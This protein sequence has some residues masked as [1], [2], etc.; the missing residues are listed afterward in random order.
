MNKKKLVFKQFSID[1]K[2]FYNRFLKYIVFISYCIYF[3]YSLFYNDSTTL[4]KANHKYEYYSRDTGLKMTLNAKFPKYLLHIH[5][6]ASFVLVMGA[7]FLKFSTLQLAKASN[8]KIIK[9]YKSLHVLV[10]YATLIAAICMAVAGFFLGYYSDL[11]NFETFS[12]FFAGPWF[13]FFFGIYYSA[14]WKLWG[15]HRVLGNMLVKGCIAVPLVRILGS[16]L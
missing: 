7:F 8:V 11:D 6:F 1:S 10:G 4:P 14:K 5:S 9:L 16:Y 15:W 3:V 12:Y 2:D 13:V